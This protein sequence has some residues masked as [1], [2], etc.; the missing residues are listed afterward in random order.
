MSSIAQKVYSFML[1]HAML[2]GSRSALIAVSGGPDSVGLLDILVR[3]LRQLG[4]T[5]E[6]FSE[7]QQAAGN[8]GARTASSIKADPGPG[9]HRAVEAGPGHGTQPG[10][11][12][13][14]A[15]LNHKLR[16]KAADD[17]A[18]FVSELAAHLGLP[19]ILGTA[20]V[21]AIASRLKIG[22]EEAARAARYSFLFQAAAVSGADRIIT[23]HT[24][25]DQVETF[26]MRAARGAGTAGLAGMAPV[27][28]AHRFEGIES[29]MIEAVM[30][31][32]VMIETDM[33]ETDEF[34]GTRSGR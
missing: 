20:D 24:M 2:S 21:T 17:D 23:G 29:V 11:G 9:K 7:A 30:I 25:N 14:L 16:G 34:Q 15:H 28:P 8:S 26:M 31:E 12:L 1:E 10:F 27:R 3:L 22:I 6:H 4:T 32:T 5:S 18:R 19:A 13:I 33:I